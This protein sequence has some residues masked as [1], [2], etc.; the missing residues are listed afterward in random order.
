[1]AAKRDMNSVL[2]ATTEATEG[3]AQAATNSTDVVLLENLQVNFNES[4][5]VTQE[6][7]GTLDPATDIPIGGPCSVSFDTWLKGSGTAGTA[8]EIGKL[9]KACGWGETITSSAL[10]N[11]STATATGNSVTLSTGVFAGATDAYKGMIALLSINP[12]SSTYTNITAFNN[13]TGVM[14]FAET[15]AISL[16]PTTV[17]TLPKNV[18]YTPVSPPTTIPSLT[19]RAYKDGVLST[20]AGCRGTFKMAMVAGQGVKLSWSFSGI[21]A[22]PRTDSANPTNASPD[23]AQTKLVWRNDSQNGGFLADGSRIGVAGLNFD[24][25]I[26][27][28]NAPNPNQPSGYDVADIGGRVM[29]GDFNPRL[30]S[31]ATKDWLA[32][33]R[34]GTTSIL[35][36]FALNAAGN[37][38]SILMP[39][40]NL[41]AYGYEKQGPMIGQKLP[42]KAT[43]SNTG[44]YICFF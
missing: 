24:N 35:S 8:P 13:S 11:T 34:A 40:A 27:L 42:L 31:I 2:T 5:Q 29:R 32:R 23:S 12:A 30:T 38:S 39:A 18:L 6:V 4:Q 28:D 43:G 1:M 9:F 15:F 20:L 25:G 19:L 21:M 7:T 36:A 3:V 22:Q 16:G 41:T 17:V 37:A 14:T 44:A 33:K 10:V 26:S